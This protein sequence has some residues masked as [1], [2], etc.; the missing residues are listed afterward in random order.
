[1]SHSAGAPE[2]RLPP[3]PSPRHVQCVAA[4]PTMTTL[5][6]ELM[7]VGGPTHTPRKER[8]VGDSNCSQA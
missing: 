8:L 1:M 4:S 5:C 3:L 6:S 2:A 7:V